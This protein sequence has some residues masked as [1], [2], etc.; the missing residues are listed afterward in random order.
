MRIKLAGSGR[1][2]QAL[3]GIGL[4]FARVEAPSLREQAADGA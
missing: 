2:E 3:V 4:A 1:I